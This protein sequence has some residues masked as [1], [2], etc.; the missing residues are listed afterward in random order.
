MIQVGCA[1]AGISSAAPAVKPLL[2]AIDFM[3]SADSSLLS[4]E[5]FPI[6]HNPQMAPTAP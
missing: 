2:P 3:G 6:P 1:G 4:S 5:L